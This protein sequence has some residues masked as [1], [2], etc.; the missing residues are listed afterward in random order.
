MALHTV[1]R[2]EDV[3]EP[4]PAGDFA[5]VDVLTAS[6]SIVALLDQGASYVRP[7]ADADAARAFG[8]AH[9][10]AVLVGEEHGAPLPGFDFLPLPTQ[11]RHADLQDRPVGIRTTNGT[12]AVERIGQVGGLFVGSTTNAGAVA[13]TLA[14]SDRDSY[15]VA[16][17]ER[18]VRSPEDSAGVDLIEAHCS[19]GPD[20]GERESVRKQIGECPA[21]EWLRGL[22]LEAEID[23]VLSFDSTRTVP[24]LR[25]GVFVAD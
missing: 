2:I 12:R 24:R 17:G 15:I 16:A 9:D 5:V 18:G 3:P 21:A 6:T 23:A 7:F 4:T 1:E 19:G 25:D 20:E 8:G 13:D 22:G 14:A 10:D 11:F